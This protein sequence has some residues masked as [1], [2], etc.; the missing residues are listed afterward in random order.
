MK[1]VAQ[2]EATATLGSFR[3]RRA[4]YWTVFQEARWVPVRVWYLS[5]VY[6]I[7]M[8]NLPLLTAHLVQSWHKNLSDP[9]SVHKHA[10]GQGSYRGGSSIENSDSLPIE[11]HGGRVTSHKSSFRLPWLMKTDECSLHFMFCIS[12]YDFF[13]FILE[14]VRP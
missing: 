11:T 8:V 10:F 13:F 3:Q 1:V 7:R 9:P 4:P 2:M 14:I 5:F 12:P 6:H